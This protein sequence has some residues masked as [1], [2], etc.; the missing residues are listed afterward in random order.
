MRANGYGADLEYD[1][2][3]VMIYPG[4]VMARATGAKRIAIPVLDIAA[5]EYKKANALVNGQM[6]L[7]LKNEHQ[8]TL[9]R[10]GDRGPLPIDDAERL[11][12]AKQGL[13]TTESLVV[14][15]RKK[16]QGDFEALHEQILTGL[17]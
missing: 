9:A 14:A 16:D 15:W 4:R 10:Y 1:G 11:A 2:T 8:E 17:R 7:K 5:V 3:T 6:R 13:I 12:Y